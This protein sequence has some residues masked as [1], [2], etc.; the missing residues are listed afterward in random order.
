M[1]L[2]LAAI[3]TFSLAAACSRETTAV[4][5]ASFGRLPDGA[6]V[7][8]YTLTNRRGMEVR[9]MTYGATIISVRV[10]DRT[11][12]VEDVVLGFDG[13]ADYLTKARYFGS[14]RGR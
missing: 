2:L 1:R 3:A 4:N 5:R 11:G 8:A 13:I 7:D 14:V 9:A 6:L 10:P 12:R